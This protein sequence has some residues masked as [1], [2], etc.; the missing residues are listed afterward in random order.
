MSSILPEESR[1]LFGDAATA[2]ELM[3]RIRT[4]AHLWFD[5]D[6]TLM[7]L[8]R[9]AQDSQRLNQTSVFGTVLL[10]PEHPFIMMFW[11]K[12]DGSVQWRDA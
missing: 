2:P 5:E 11:V 3:C 9:C 12:P 7:S 1:A 8:N 4:H 6:S 10:G